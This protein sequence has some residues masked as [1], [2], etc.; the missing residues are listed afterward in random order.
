MKPAEILAVVAIA[1]FAI[2]QLIELFDPVISGL[3]KRFGKKGESEQELRYP[4]ALSE[5]DFKKSVVM[6][7]SFLLGLLV[8]WVSEIKIL[9]AVNEKWGGDWG[10]IFVT[11]LVIGA[12]TEGLNTLTK[13]F[14]YMKDS[15]KPSPIQVSIIPSQVAVRTNATVQFL[16]S[17]A[18]TR[19]TAVTWSVPQSEGGTID[20]ESGLY[21]APS[22]A[23][24][25]QVLAISRA[26]PTKSASA[27]V[28]V[29]E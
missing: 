12:G 22:K 25:Y 13:Y 5:A 10:D 27:V 28:T 16:A 15:R 19:N 8:A 20:P 18:H 6:A 24:T 26:D 4:G 7:L 1:G 11:A 17:V 21:T 14:N 3:V 29:R 9:S 2:Q 23:G